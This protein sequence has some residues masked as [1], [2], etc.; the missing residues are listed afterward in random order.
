MLKIGEARIDGEPVFTGYLRDV[1]EDQ[2][3]QHRLSN[4]QIELENY[5]RL[6][7]VGSMASAM[8]HELN[9]PLT[10]IANYLEAARDIVADRSLDALPIVEEAL[11]AAAGQSIKAGKIVRRL[12]DYVSRGEIEAQP[13]S[14]QS[15]IQDALSIAKM[16]RSGPTPRIENNV[17]AGFPQIRADRLQIRQVL[18]NL[19]RNAVEAL[20][21]EDIPVIRITA[22]K[23]GDKALVCVC[24]NGPGLDIEE[25]HSPFDPFISTK[26]SGMG[27]GL[28]ICQT[29]IQAHNGEIWYEPIEPHGARFCFT[30][31]LNDTGAGS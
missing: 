21:D 20:G 12:R 4:M 9:Q 16:G 10:A 23:Q 31:D 18:F 17:A 24:D 7:A 6:N 8:A 2:E 26:S 30:L 29:I 13:A 15:L 14:L 25:G 5:S 22:E 19:L 27:L 3:R 11:D 1:T 28:S